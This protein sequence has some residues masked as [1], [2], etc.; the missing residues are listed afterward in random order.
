MLKI[1]EPHL[2]FIR[3]KIESLGLEKSE[4]IP[5]TSNGFGDLK[6]KRT[7]L[8]S[9]TNGRVRSKCEINGKQVTLK[10]LRSVSMPLIT[11]VDASVASS[12]LSQGK[13]RTA[14]IDT[15]VSNKLLSQVRLTKREY[16]NARKRREAMEREI[17]N[18]VLPQSFVATD[19]D[20][21]IEL[22][23]HWI[24]ELDEFQT[25]VSTFQDSI[26]SS[27]GAAKILTS[28]D[29]D[30][31]IKDDD[32]E[33]INT[34]GS[35]FADILRK[36]CNCSWEKEE[37]SGAEPISN[38]FYSNLLDL[39]DGVRNL[40]SKLTSAR[41][42]C[43]AL[44]SLSSSQ[45]V[46]FAL[47]ES[48]KHLF[49]ATAGHEDNQDLIDAAETSHELLNKL[50][51]ALSSCVNFMSDHPL[52]L[53]STLEKMR[54]SIHISVEDFD[55]LIADWG[56]LARKHGVSPFSLPSLHHSL[57]QELDG[58]VE[59]RLML[60]KAKEEEK[61]AL[62]NFEK[63]CKALSQA[64]LKVCSTLTS[65]VTSRLN[66]LGMEGST[67][68]SQLNDKIY[69]CTDSAAYSDGNTLGTDGVTFLLTHNDG[70]PQEKNNSGHLDVI[71]SSGEK[72]RLLLAIETDL[73][74]SIGASCNSLNSNGVETTEY[75]DP[76][77]VAV[78]YDEIDAHVGGRAAVSVAK[79]LSDQAQCKNNNHPK[80]AKRTQVITITHSPSLA[81]IADRH[82][83]VKKD[84]GPHGNQNEKSV[85]VDVVKGLSR[86]EEIS[87][88]T[89][90]D[91]ALKESMNFAEALLRD[92]S[93]YKQH[94]DAAQSK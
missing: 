22:L 8:Q 69:Q 71:G 38:L 85:I 63:A 79:L 41:S 84:L 53:L 78:V 86:L 37:R 73:P 30:H 14:I 29:N 5:I 19:S 42:S 18:R 34:E 49:D 91:L 65:S 23:Q 48:R 43:D 66:D 94:G 46:A 60:P 28:D 58:N 31:T 20:E 74:G 32:G 64:R 87:R 88:M 47:E 51:D 17:E 35:S 72:A 56:S 36:F 67:F 27:Q 40:D 62:D 21:N 70:N 33:A 10:T 15:G 44:S 25:R 76:G 68:T 61:I 7:I 93:R 90:G 83:V 39:R 4:M 12:A 77:P 6:L 52:G 59:A 1:S 81:A 75:S 45:S 82:I 54:Q 50:E 24:D 11:V 26:I 9:T 55:F 16:R 57:R 80:S 89:S 3:E 2:G 13:A 92:G